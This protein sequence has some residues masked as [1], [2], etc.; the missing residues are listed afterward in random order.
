MR[1]QLINTLEDLEFADDIALLSHR[2]QDMRCKME[3]LKAAGEK[4]GLKINAS[5]TKL[6]K[7][8]TKQDVA[9]NIGQ[10]T[11]EEVE[12]FQ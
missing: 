1:W 8:M 10:E 3:D 5:K 6:L 4:V 11:V 7:V 2:L 12:E 9:V